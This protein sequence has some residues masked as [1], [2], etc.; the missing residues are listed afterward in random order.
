MTRPTLVA[1]WG[2]LAILLAACG[3]HGAEEGATA[4]PADAAAAE[5]RAQALA[6]ATWTVAASENQRFTLAVSTPVRYGA[7]DAWVYR[8]LVGDVSCS[9]GVFG[10]PLV[11]VVKRCEVQAGTPSNAAAPAGN[12]TP[13]NASA[14]S[15]W[16]F[17][18]NENESFT[19]AGTRTVRY[20]A[21]STWIEKSVTSAGTCSNG[22][23]G[24]DPLVGV[25][26]R[27]ETSSGTT[28]GTGTPGTST[29]PTSASNASG[30]S[31]LA[32]E[33]AGFSLA[34][35]RTVRYGA[36]SSWVQREVSGNATCNNAFFGSDPL[37]GVV[38]RCEVSGATSAGTAPAAAPAPTQTPTPTQPPAASPAPSGSRSSAGI[39]VS[40]HSLT[41]HPVFAHMENIARSLGTAMAWNQQNIPGSPMRVRTR[42]DN[43]SDPSFAGYRSGTNRNGTNMNVV[44]E[45]VSPQT[46]GGARYD[47]LILA[48]RH[49]L[50]GTLLW[51][52]TVRYARH[53]HDR[54]VAGN[55]NAN[56]YLYHSWLG[57]VD[58]NNPWQWINYE[59]A[60]APAWQCV[61]ARVS[62]SLAAEGRPNRMTYLPAGLA[63]ANLVEQAN[64]SWLPGIS[65]GSA[66]ATHDRL[67]SD[68]VHL[69]PLG[70]YYMALVTY[71]SVYRR[72]PAGAWAPPEVSAEQAQSLQQVAWQSV[73]NYYNSAPSRSMAE[74]QSLMVNQVCP[75]FVSYKNMGG[76]YQNYCASRFS[77]QSQDNPFWFD[78]GSDAWYWYPAPQ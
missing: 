68:D 20:G 27:C 38:K 71:A 44:S 54:L 12:T 73:A 34:G 46:L 30:W 8:T 65:G 7:N 72:S 64:Q 24:R 40:G 3:G 21:G 48:E 60:V 6:T 17:V 22:F 77:V 10:D 75:A 35:V 41:A 14:A 37:P 23:F 29:T 15:G 36:A 67:F 76:D 74:C 28:A 47:T 39:L 26:K 33:G 62:T 1:L 16:A 78:W 56:S 53:Y 59:R 51:E 43:A 63:L 69:K 25:V 42:G 66:A 58:K 57:V 31:F 49:D 11:N 18:A 52:D 45:L 19:V 50:P 4:T 2:S 32:N 5:G 61:A 70:A 9:N 13:A 55:N